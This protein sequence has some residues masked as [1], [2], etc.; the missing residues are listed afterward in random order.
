[1]LV[2]HHVVLVS[3]TA[4]V[5]SSRRGGGTA[6]CGHPRQRAGVKD[7]THAFASGG[8]RVPTGRELLRSQPPLTD[9]QRAAPP[10]QTL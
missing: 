3:D 8:A 10:A 7:V 2:T 9:R 6:R 1:M 4:S 5:R